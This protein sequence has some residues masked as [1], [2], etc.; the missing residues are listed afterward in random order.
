[1]TPRSTALP[2]ACHLPLHRGCGCP[3]ASPALNCRIAHHRVDMLR[4]GADAT[5]KTVQNLFSE[6]L[7]ADGTNAAV[8]WQDYGTSRWQLWNKITTIAGVHV[9]GRSSYFA[10]REAGYGPHFTCRSSLRAMNRPCSVELCEAR[11]PST[12]LNGL[13]LL[14]NGVIFPGAATGWSEGQTGSMSGTGL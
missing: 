7:P 3:S 14:G 5:R 2:L 4:V 8:N 9:R 6:Y 10:A 13:G 1:M 11:L 12:T